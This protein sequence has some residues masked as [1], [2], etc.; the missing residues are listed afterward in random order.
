MKYTSLRVR[1]DRKMA[2]Q[3]AAIDI[4]YKTGEPIRWT[5]IANTL[6]DK[7]LDDI[8]KDLIAKKT[9]TAKP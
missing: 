8:K 4:S 1:E 2:L 6:F 5:D 3:Q 7:Y 9:K